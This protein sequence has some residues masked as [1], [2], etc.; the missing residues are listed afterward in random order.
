MED[1][2]NENRLRASA[3]WFTVNDKLAGLVSEAAV[4]IQVL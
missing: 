4:F 3:V 1:L 2:H